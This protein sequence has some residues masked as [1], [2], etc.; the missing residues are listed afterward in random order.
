MLK[1][2]RWSIK[3]FNTSKFQTFKSNSNSDLTGMD[4]VLVFRNKK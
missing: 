1:N 2:K 4:V 3:I